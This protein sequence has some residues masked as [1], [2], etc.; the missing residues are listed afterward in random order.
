VVLLES[1]PEVLAFDLPRYPCSRGKG[2]LSKNI[3]LALS[4]EDV[5]IRLLTLLL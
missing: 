3:A 2:K 4:G 1:F 5:L